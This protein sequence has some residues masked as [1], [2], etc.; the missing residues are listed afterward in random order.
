MGLLAEC[1]SQDEK[2]AGLMLVREMEL[3]GMIHVYSIS[4]KKKKDAIYYNREVMESI[5]MPSFRG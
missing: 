5:N 2:R 4:M 3:F 1:Y